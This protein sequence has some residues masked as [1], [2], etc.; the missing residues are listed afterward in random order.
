M[1]GGANLKP[2]GKQQLSFLLVKI[3][4]FKDYKDVVIA[5]IELTKGSAS[6]DPKD[7]LVIPRTYTLLAL[8]HSSQGEFRK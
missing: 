2:W 7:S 8:P 3:F 6:A 4:D 5:A 1:A